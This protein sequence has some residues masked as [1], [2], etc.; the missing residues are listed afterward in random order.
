MRAIDQRRYGDPREVLQLVE[1]D[2]PKIT[3]DRRGDL[4]S[5]AGEVI[6]AARVFRVSGTSR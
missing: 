1:M 4:Q 2:V 6:N 5:K 3:A